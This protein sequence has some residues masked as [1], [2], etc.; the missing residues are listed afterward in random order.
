MTVPH[1]RA[2]WS[3][4]KK[5][6]NNRSGS[7]HTFSYMPERRYLVL[8]IET[9][10]DW[11][12]VRDV[13]G[14]DADA[15]QEQMR[16]QIKTKYSSGFAPPPFHVPICIA[17]ID[18]DWD[19]CKIANAAVLENNDEK[20][21]LQH[22]WKVAR[23]RKGSSVQT[24]FVHF[25][26]RSFDL[27]VLF[28]R[29]LKYRVPVLTTDRSRYSFE[30][31]HDICDDLA[32]F[33]AAP[34]PSLDLISKLL[35]LPGKTDIQGSQ[36]EDLYLQGERGRIKD[37]CMEDALSTYHIWL[38]MKLVRGE[39]TDEKYREAFE[40]AA[41]TVRACRSVTDNYFGGA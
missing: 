3:E 18:V 2:R 29:S 35:G 25:N 19:T 7:G 22:F 33:G 13:F 15:T 20:T 41:T 16:E 11:N 37:Y 4:C 26:G 30:S 5:L 17:L 1:S 38:T 14:M 12:L 40:T 36:V 34:R 6:S 24:T 39:L 21:L 8:D 28:Y 9:V 23:H 32:E 27:P 31:S 10:L